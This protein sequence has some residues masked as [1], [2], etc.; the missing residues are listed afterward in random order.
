[1]QSLYL[2]NDLE[3]AVRSGDLSV[4]GNDVFSALW[5]VEGEVYRRSARRRTSRVVIAGK[6]YF[7]K[8]HEGVGWREIAKNVLAGKRPVLG[9]RHDFEA[10]RR[11]CA[12]GVA[13]PGLAAF[14]E[15]GV[16]PARRRSFAMHDA[17]DGFR[18]LEDVGHG[19]LVT[20]PSVELKWALLSEAGRL[21][22]AMHEAGV[23]HR[24]Y[25]ACHL[26]A[27]TAK[28]GTGEAELSV[29]DLHRAEVH[30][31][32]S[33]RA[34]VRDLGALL[35]S[36]SAMPLTERDRSRFVAA[37]AGTNASVELR[38][39][40]GFWRAV[41]RRAERL[42]E[43]AVA[44]G[45]ATGAK[46][47][48]ASGIASVGRLADLD[49][50][51][52]LP[53]RFDVTLDSPNGTDACRQA[54]FGTMVKSALGRLV[55][56]RGALV[57]ERDALGQGGV[58]ALCTAILRAQPGRRL[59]LRA[60]VDGREMILKAFFGP[61]ADRDST[62]E[63]RGVTALRESG[64]ATPGL[65]GVGRG[66]GAR[67]LAFEAL[68][69]AREPSVGDVGELL[70]T[71]GRMHKSGIRQHDL[72]PGNFLVSGRRLFVIDGGGVVASRSVD[73]ACRLSDVARLLAHF[74]SD[75]LG[76]LAP[77][78]DAYEDAAGVALPKQPPGGLHARVA[79]ARRHRVAKF[80]AKT[81][82][83]CTAFAVREE[84]RRR[85]VVT[86]GDDDPEL[87]D[88]VADPDRA[89]S[90]GEPLKHGNTAAAVRCGGFVVKRYNVKDP[91][92]RHRLRW[93]RTRAQRAWRAGHGLRFAGLATPRPRALIEMRRPQVGEAVAF[94]V[95]DHVEGEPLDLAVDPDLNRALARL[96]G[97]WRE[98]RF[99]HGDTKASNFVVKDGDIYVLDLD[100]AA[101]HRRGWRFVRAHRRDRVRFLANWP[102]APASTRDA[103]GA[104][105]ERA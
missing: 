12:R 9:A 63:E 44:R 20:P 87:G 90:S 66:G 1:M 98:L 76:A 75:A 34:R 5:A 13:V 23:C 67:I 51:P 84:P 88:I 27:N 6:A 43:R 55:Y 79:R 104:A 60:E 105:G 48:G 71:L 3:V 97:A 68:G 99:A 80:M 74:P 82:R 53:F 56:P 96:F 21:T 91:W 25:Y 30:R 85:V 100:A 102:D 94:L 78:T 73:G 64:V 101:F 83:E 32:L 18:S 42:Q 77:L 33:R 8:V 36:A 26:L 59:V 86:R 14:G 24:D 45:L 7:A 10:S 47:L 72:H 17:L 81:T 92:H 89:A 62:R 57:Y 49:R 37:Y 31:R 19:W 29:I 54:A 41:Q 46:A 11:L 65:L 22:A 70:A 93:R 52:P 40:G 16:N 28:L 61:R 4:P 69:G 38:R 39:R 95:V 15:R 2:R 58:R 103:L 35:Y 50:D